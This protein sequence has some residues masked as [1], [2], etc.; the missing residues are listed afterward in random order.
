M[1]FGLFWEHGMNLLSLS[2]GCARG[3]KRSCACRPHVEVLESRT[4]LSVC[5]VDQLSDTGAGQEDHGDLRYCI[6]WTNNNPGPDTIT[7]AVTGTIYLQSALPH[8]SDDLRIRGPGQSL[9]TIDAQQKSRVFY[10]N[11]GIN[12][13]ISGLRLTHG[14]STTYEGGGAIYNAGNLVLENCSISRNTDALL[15][16]GISNSG[17]L[18]ISDCSISGN[19]AMAGPNYYTYGG[20]IY[21][22]TLGVLT[23]NNSVISNNEIQYHFS[24]VARGGGIANFGTATIAYS[25]ISGNQADP[26]ASDAYGADG[27]GIYNAGKVVVDS[28]LISMNI[29]SGDLFSY[30]GG[31]YAAGGGNVTVVNSTIADNIAVT[32]STG[33]N[34]A[35]ARGGGIS[36]SGVMIITNSTIAENQSISLSSL[37][38]AY[39]GGISAGGSL[40]VHNTIVSGNYATTDGPDLWGALAHSG[41]NLF[42][43]SA[44]GSGY[45]PTDLLNFDPVLGPLADNG[46]P[47]QTIALLPGSPAI[48]AGDNTNAPEWDQRGEGFPRI[49]NGII[50]I[51]AFEVQQPSAIAVF[52]DAGRD[53]TSALFS[54]AATMSEVLMP[55][56][57]E[58]WIG[59]CES[60]KGALAYC[61]PGLEPKIRIDDEY[62]T[63]VS[64]AAPDEVSMV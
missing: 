5:T 38:K 49:V 1:H 19:L 57:L 60:P 33:E 22:Y 24:W 64:V 55:V 44:G 37:K 31:I 13:Q 50:D 23:I 63:P 16:G 59:S 39:G 12:A 61:P 54:E 9:L 52:G 29:A 46:G 56:Q 42:G 25:T 21:N 48:D 14:F 11:A 3:A 17:T 26:Y 27:G 2:F 10:V 53:T 32:S 51:G 30:G 47:T 8:L 58:S 28:A 43:D 7:F 35:E 45:D 40:T 15:G 20:G 41:Y 62:L 6:N 36:C 34:G 18:S 4:L